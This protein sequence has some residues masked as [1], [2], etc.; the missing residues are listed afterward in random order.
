MSDIV[1]GRYPNANPN[2]SNWG[3]QTNI[4]QKN[5]P[6]YTNAYPGMALAN[7]TNIKNKEIS[8]VPVQ[9][10]GGVEISRIYFRIVKEKAETQ[11][12]FYTGLWSGLSPTAIGGE[13][14]PK[15]LA[16]SKTN[17]IVYPEALSTAA[18]VE[19]AMLATT[20]IGAEL[21]KPVLVEEGPKGNAP[22]GWIYVGIYVIATGKVISL[23]GYAAATTESTKAS[24]ALKVYPWFVG[25]PLSGFFTKPANET[26]VAP[27][28]LEEFTLSAVNPVVWLA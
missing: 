2:W 23:A 15:L 14:K 3:Q 27:E 28:F 24:S 22:Y 19:G 12:Q 21:E 11:T 25:A 8:V 17:T 13:V 7:Q 26:G 5:V 4:A 6:V 1:S 18:A 16:Q 10:P 20:T 9:V